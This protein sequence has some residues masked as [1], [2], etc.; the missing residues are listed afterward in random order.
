VSRP[1]RP[2]RKASRAS[3]KN[4]ASCFTSNAHNVCVAQSR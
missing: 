2:R 4:S 3:A 1:M